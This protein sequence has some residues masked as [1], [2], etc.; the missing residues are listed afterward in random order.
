VLARLKRE[1]E[2]L[3][4]RIVA[5]EVDIEELES[6][7]AQASKLKADQIQAAARTHAEKK[8]ALAAEYAIWD[9]LTEEIGSKSRGLEVA[10]SKAKRKR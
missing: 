6:T 9:R 1:L 7:L 10:E 4:D 3:E 5:L 8:K 2:S